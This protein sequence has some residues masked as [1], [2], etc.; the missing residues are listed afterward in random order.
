MKL[1]EELK[2]RIFSW[3]I[4]I[5]IYTLAMYNKKT[6]I[7]FFAFVS[8]LA[9]KEFCSI[10]SIRKTDY[11]VIGILYLL[12]II[13]YFFVYIDWYNLFVIFIPVYAFM[14]LCILLTLTQNTEDFLRNCGT[15]YLGAMISIYSMSQF[16]YF[17]NLKLTNS[18]M[19]I[20]TVI[21]CLTQLNDI[22]QYICGKS[23]GKR[24]IIQKVSPNKTWTGLLGGILLTILSFFLIQYF[25]F[26]EQL[27]SFLQIIIIG[28]SIS[29]FGFLGDVFISAIKRDLNI[30]DTSQLIPGHGG[31]LDR[32]D[33]LV[34]VAPLSF[35]IVRYFFTA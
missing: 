33:S 27:F 16:A 32:I 12:G 14:I 19:L 5:M 18:P 3:V 11:S 26:V 8:Y 2:K 4:M 20:M 34:F 35:H 30:K 28:S 31:I 21:I 22:F 9:I 6:I 1:S 13:Q 15:L 24:K 17:I 29:I 23:F 25:L 7:L 10:V